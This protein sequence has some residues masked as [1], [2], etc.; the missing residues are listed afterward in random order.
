MK[1]YLLTMFC[2]LLIV[3]SS[4]GLVA[5]KKNKE[6]NT[7]TTPE[8]YTVAFK[9][10][11]SDD[12]TY[13]T[14]K[15]IY[16]MTK[17]ELINKSTNEV[18]DYVT[19]VQ[20]FYVSI[21]KL[22]STKTFETFANFDDYFPLVAVGNNNLVHT[23]LG[24]VVNFKVYFKTEKQCPVS[25]TYESQMAIINYYEVSALGFTENM[26]EV[27]N[28]TIAVPQQDINIIYY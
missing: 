7:P 19:S 4:F 2:L 17:I 15:N 11:T 26:P 12:I 25:V 23:Q 22:E 1:K 8:I 20:G 10:I 24:C 16:S 21:D 28:V 5:C 27:L 9:T 3:T 14:N 18:I 6:N 13:A